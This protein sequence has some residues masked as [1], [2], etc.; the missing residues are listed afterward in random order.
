MTN[1]EE[2]TMLIVK[3]SLK[4]QCENLVYV[5]TVIHIF[6]S[7]EL[8][9]LIALLLQVLM[10]IILIKKAI[11]KNC[12]PFNKCISEIN[13]AQADNV[14]DIDIVMPIYSLIEYSDNYVKTS[15]CLWQYC[16]D[17]PPLDNNNV[18]TFFTEANPT[19]S[20]NFKAKTTSQTRDNA[21]KNVEIM[22]SLKYLSNFWR[23]LEIPLL[24][25]EINLILTWSSTYYCFY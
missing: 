12:A 18:I 20:F 4:L 5:I 11:F 23:T 7:K 1:Q 6:L 19:D 2:H 17:I 16:K 13:N 3:S 9:V 25:C 8:L 21:T 14:K 22:V 15:G 24:N 10:Q